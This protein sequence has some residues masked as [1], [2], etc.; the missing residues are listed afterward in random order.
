[1]KSALQFASFVSLLGLAAFV[2]AAEEKP[3]G[4]SLVE[5]R[6]LIGWEY[7]AM[8]PRGWHVVEGALI[9]EKDATPLVSGWSL[10]DFELRFRWAATKGSRWII[11]LPRVPGPLSRNDEPISIDLGVGDAEGKLQIEQDKSGQFTIP[12]EREHTATVRRSGTKL[13]ATVS[14]KPVSEQQIPADLR[15]GLG[16]TFIGTE[17]M[18][19]DLRIAEPAGQPLFNGKDLSG[20]WTPGKL[21][22]WDL[23]AG[24]VVCL[25]KDG[26]Y[27]RTEREYGNFTLSFDYR[28]AKGGNSGIGIRTAREGWPS[29]DGMEL[30]LL[31]EPVGTPLTRSSTM[32]IY[33]NLEP[34]AR[35]DRSEQ[36]NHAVIKA[37]GYMI[38]AWM[39][40]ELVQHANTEFLPELKHRNLKGWIGLQDHNARVEFRDMRVLAAPDGT[41]LDLWHKTPRP[42]ASELVLDRLMNPERLA[43]PGGLESVSVASHVDQTSEQVLADLSGPGALVQ[44]SRTDASGQVAIYFDGAEKPSI[45]CPA[46]ELAK[47]VPEVSLDK[48][49]LLTYLPFEK[50]LKIL[51]SGAQPGQCRIDYVKLP[52]GVILDSFDGPLESTAR[53]LLPAISYRH[54]QL[55]WGTHR[56]ADPLPR[57]SSGKKTIEPKSSLPLVSLE[58]AGVVEWLKLEM[59]KRYLANND[60]WLEITVDGES[61]PAIAA[62][63][64]FFFP[65]M[66]QAKN[67]QNFVVL[68]RHGFTNLLAMPY[69]KGLSVSASNRGK[70]PIKDIELTLSVDSAKTSTSKSGAYPLRL[71]GQFLKAKDATFVQQSGSGRLVGL[72]MAPAEQPPEISKVLVDGQPAAGGSNVSLSAWLGL[73]ESKGDTRLVLSGRSGGL[74][75]RYFLLAPINFRE[76]LAIEAA[77]GQ[78]LGD[79]LVLFYRE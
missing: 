20:W 34:F 70:R 8:P 60:L 7:G 74:W 38:S 68:N 55:G 59:S 9:A 30:Q 61:K 58:G 27:L 72:V 28:I 11:N 66:E 10:G 53:G 71:R 22:C 42:R 51:L 16:L 36:W 67:Y 23:I 52:T 32:G 6:S 13:E 14:G 5:E 3:W 79:R 46:S 73:P 65:G 77:P 64:R 12:F 43:M 41:G 19:R 44:L 76:S 29:G 54:E 33:G 57:F 49:P 39:N 47:H 1:M 21:E 63:A 24:G 56:E 31:D 50:S 78:P 17:G 69:G 75:W 18:I 48:N 26:N 25:N 45:H 4:Q 40:G 62:P 15:V 37:D 2:P 35:A